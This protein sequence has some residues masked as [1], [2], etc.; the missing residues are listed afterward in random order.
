MIDRKI[1]LIKLGGSVITDKTKPYT[2]K[3]DVLKQIIKKLAEIKCP[4]IISH[5]QGSFAHTSAQE[6]GGNKGYKNKIG[7]AKI[8]LDVQVLQE[9]LI[10]ELLKVGIPAIGIR[11][12]GLMFANKGKILQHNFEILEE[13]LT[14]GFVPVVCGDLV[15]DKNWK[16]NIFSGEKILLFLAQYFLKKNYTLSRIIQVTNT[17]G[18]YDNNK[19]TIKNI[20]N[21]NWGNIKKYIYKSL[22]V[23]I[24]GAMFH[25]IE[26]A[27]LLSKLNVSTVIINGNHPSEILKSINFIPKKGTIVY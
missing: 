8:S 11:P 1:I 15:F 12:I 25:K 14:Q 18:V 2:L 17:N 19:K 3:L 27:L 7:L 24:T 21:N 9:I 22:E 10:K 4:F 5:G 16:T 6:F 26:N 23:D 13:A 20:T